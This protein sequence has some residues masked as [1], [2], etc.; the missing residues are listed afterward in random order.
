MPDIKEGEHET[1]YTFAS[2]EVNENITGKTPGHITLKCEGGTVGNLTLRVLLNPWGSLEVLAGDVVRVYALQDMFDSTLFG[3]MAV[4]VLGRTMVVS[5]TLSGLPYIYE[6]ARTGFKYTG[7]EYDGANPCGYYIN[8]RGSEDIW[9]REAEY[10]AIKDGFNEWEN[11]PLSCKDFS[12]IGYTDH[13]YGESDEMNVV[14]WMDRGRWTPLGVIYYYVYGGKYHQFDTVFNDYYYWSL[15]VPNSYDVRSAMTHEAGHALG[16]DD[17]YWAENS[18]QTMFNAIGTGETKKRTIESGD[19]A[20]VQYLYPQYE[21][22]SVTIIEPLNGQEVGLCV[23]VIA[24]VSS[25]SGINLVQCV[26]YDSAYYSSGWISMEYDP[27]LGNW[28][29]WWYPPFA[30]GWH[31]LMVRAL[32]NQGMYGYGIIDVWVNPW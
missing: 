14:C 9:D 22:P 13:L 3:A 30:E 29:G 4:D 17:L 24:S 11:D 23:R 20:G 26:G 16:L 5:T 21:Q 28:V 19:R 18:E 1:I 31:K 25:S 10:Q 15:G 8:Y 2:V 7:P 6:G 27:S 12:F 32:N